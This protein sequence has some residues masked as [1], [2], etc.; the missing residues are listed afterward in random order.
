MIQNARPRQ[1]ITALNDLRDI[2][3]LENVDDVTRPEAY[4]FS[5]IDL[6]EPVVE[7]ICLLTDELDAIMTYLKAI[8]AQKSG[9]E[10]DAA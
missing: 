4:F 9:N 3:A 2:L 7:G 10:R 1:T 6:S 8:C 5:A